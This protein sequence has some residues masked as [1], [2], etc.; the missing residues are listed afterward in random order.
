VARR[1]VDPDI[2]EQ[3]GAHQ[4][5]VLEAIDRAG[6]VAGGLRCDPQPTLGGVADGLHDVVR[7]GGAH[8]PGRPL[9]VRQVEGLPG[10]VPAL[11]DLREDL[12]V[13]AGLKFREAT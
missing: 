9:V 7:V 10:G 1:Y 4:E 8:E 2:L 12:A 6:V 13:N 3:V 5:R 11:I